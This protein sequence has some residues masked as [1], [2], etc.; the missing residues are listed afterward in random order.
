MIISMNVT[1][2]VAMSV[3]WCITIS[4]SMNTESSLFQKSTWFRFFT[5]NLLLKM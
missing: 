3:A 4:I 1:F 5:F 2:R